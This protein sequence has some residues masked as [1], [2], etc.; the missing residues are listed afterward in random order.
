MSVAAAG[1]CD[2][3][4]VGWACRTGWASWAGWAGEAKIQAIR[5]EGGKNQVRG[6]YYKLQINTTLRVTHDEDVTVIYDEGSQT[7]GKIV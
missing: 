5:T 4:M 3:V 7:I 1:C 2:E 6:R